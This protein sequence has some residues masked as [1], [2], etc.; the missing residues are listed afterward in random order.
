M[1]DEI[2]K[3]KVSVAF[4]SRLLFSAKKLYDIGEIENLGQKES[5]VICAHPDDESLFF[6][7]VIVEHTDVAVIC[8]SNRSNLTRQ[9]EFI[10]AIKQYRVQ[11]IICDFPDNSYLTWAWKLFLPRMMCILNNRIRPKKVYTHNQNGEYG[12]THHIITHDCVV[13]V[14]GD[15]V[16]STSDDVVETLQ[17]KQS[18]RQF[19]DEVY[20]SQN[21]KQW[22]P[23]YY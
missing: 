6:H 2:L 4:L 8:L 3:W 10:N 7:K 20:K 13:N 21:L 22:F 18:R 1:K 19:L 11:G 5:L 12:H 17:E 16:V 15:D 23:D 14:F 9:A